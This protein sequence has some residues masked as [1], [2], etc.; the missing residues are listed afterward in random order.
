MV[1]EQLSSQ[2]SELDTDSTNRDS[3]PSPDNNKAGINKTIAPTNRSSQ[4]Q[5]VSPL[6]AFF[7]TLR[8]SRSQKQHP[9]DHSSYESLVLDVLGQYDRVVCGLREECDSLRAGLRATIQ[10]HNEEESSPQSQQHGRMRSGAS[11]VGHVGGLNMWPTAYHHAHNGYGAVPSSPFMP[12]PSVYA[13]APGNGNALKTGS[14]VTGIE[15]TGSGS[16]LPSIGNHRGVR[17]TGMLSA[18]PPS[19]PPKMNRFGARHAPYR[20]HHLVHTYQTSDDDRHIQMDVNWPESE[21]PRSVRQPSY[22]HP[23]G[24]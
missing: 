3:T 21:E 8:E 20:A 17:I 1:R 10:E 11:R 14:V 5:H 9:Q 19:T 12:L 4:S 16:T 24:V 7:S 6:R 22:G 2:L 13:S 18:A 23:P 15:D